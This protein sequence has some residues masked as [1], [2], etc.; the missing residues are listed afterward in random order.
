M[1]GCVHHNEA[2]TK[3]F[4]IIFEKKKI[5]AMI[6]TFHRKNTYGLE[7]LNSCIF[8]SKEAKSALRNKFLKGAKR[9]LH[10]TV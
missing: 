2:E 4:N 3:G 1:D 8:P 5:K 9:T 7:Y 10:Y 6:Q